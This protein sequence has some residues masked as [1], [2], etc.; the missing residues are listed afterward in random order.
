MDS[1]RPQLVIIADAPDALVELFGVSML[2]RLL[3]VVQRLGF[4][5]ATIIS[6]APDEIA[7]HLAKPS[8]ARAE[9]AVTFRAR[10]TE[11]VLIS[12]VAI[13]GERTLVVSGGFYYDARL[14]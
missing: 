14:L 8:W 6:R 10:E 5:E 7:A 4:R 11:A 2:E 13:D 12:D 1:P 9:V 3:R